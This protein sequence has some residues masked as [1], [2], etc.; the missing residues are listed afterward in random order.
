MNASWLEE[1]LPH[2]LLSQRMKLWWVVFF[3]LFPLAYVGGVMLEFAKDSPARI[4]GAEDRA[5]SIRTAR[6]FAATKGFPVADCKTY[7]DVETHD[8]LLLYYK[9][10]K[11]PELAAA[12]LIAP[13]RV[14]EVMF[15]PHDQS[16]D[17]RVY[18]SLTGRVAGY[19]IGK[20]VPHR[21]GATSNAI[22]FNSSGNSDE[23]EGGG[24]S[25]DNSDDTDAEVLA[26]RAL[27]GSS[28]LLNSLITGKPRISADED[29]SARSNVI[30]TASPPGRKELTFYVTVGLRDSKVVEQRVQA[31]IDKHYLESN[32]AR[33]T[34]KYREGLYGIYG[35]FLTF[36]VIYGIYRY[37][38]RTIQKEV[39]HLRTLVVALLFL[40]SYSTLAYS[41]GM[42]VVTSYFTAKVFGQ[43][44]IAMYA[45]CIIL[46]SMMGLL[47]GIA[48]GSGEGEV[49]EA[50]PGK[51]TSLDALLVGR[52]F[53]KDVGASVLFG[54]A[55]AGWLLLCQNGIDHFLQA[56]AIVWQGT[57][58]RYTFARLPGLALLIGE[59]YDALLVAAAGLLLPASFLLRSGMKKRRGFLWLGAFALCAVARDAAGSSTFPS[60][61]L[62]LI[63]LATG[64]LLPFF[65]FDLLAAMV[66]LASLAYFS[67]L[68]ELSAAFPSWITF[69]MV[70]AALAAVT[71]AIAAYLALRGRRVRE[72]DVRPLYAKNLAER[73]S[74]QAEILAA[75]EAQLRLLPQAAPEMPGLQM[76]ACCLP[77]HGVGG[78]FYDFFPLDA[79]RIGIFVAEGGDQGL[80]S[81]LCIALAKGVLMH[82][83]MQPHSPTQIILALEASI[84]ELL[85]GGSG[86]HISF[87][88]GIIDT[89][90]NLL[91]YA[92]IGSSPRLV[93]YRPDA[94][95]TTSSQLERMVAVPHRPKSAPQVYE[96]AAHSQAGDHIIFFTNGVTSLRTRRFGNREFQWLDILMRE[97]GR[98]DAPL[99]TALVSAFSKYQRHASDD[100]TAV[101]LRIVQ[102]AALFKEGVA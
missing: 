42:D 35:L 90:R 86:I 41:V 92:R 32:L 80:A 50:F 78:D 29:D 45:G 97:L 26:R 69:S 48:Y 21:R 71:L 31:T 93:I 70:F 5:A 3:T 83:S 79:N 95:L 87:A 53:S 9:G 56:N 25:A 47:V 4:S 13:A 7:V 57:L 101:V 89:R 40:I 10:A 74:M 88:Y 62:A 82:T 28:A 38:K 66:C 44:Q 61:I 15:R 72:E 102:S 36:G 1:L 27:A 59:Q 84:A 14:I 20:S 77:A 49:R 81:A 24:K 67:E 55:V 19:W 17:L 76:A 54:A 99:Q 94:K 100:L 2:A 34:A 98:P 6:Q 8:D 30:W 39:S 46:F 18:L 58:L 43:I 63:V 68:A 52:I 51:L 33:G 75:R 12:N 23:D 96:G 73:V 37:A 91:N 22:G 11:Q 85:E 16:D 64:L 60:A 65:A